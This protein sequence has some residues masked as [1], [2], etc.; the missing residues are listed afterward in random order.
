[1]SLQMR[2]SR[3]AAGIA[4]DDDDTEVPIDIEGALLHLSGLGCVTCA[5][6][7]AHLV[8]HKDAALGAAGR[9]HCLH[10]HRCC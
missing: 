6:W 4:A 10:Q 7:S 8:L 3:R 5:L 1:M 2:R 9:R